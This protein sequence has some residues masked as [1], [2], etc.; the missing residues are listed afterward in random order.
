MVVNATFA[1]RGS[2]RKTDQKLGSRGNLNETVSSIQPSRSIERSKISK[3]SFGHKIIEK[4]VS[5]E[6][7][8][9]KPIAGT[10]IIGNT[11][12]LPDN[13]LSTERSLPRAIAGFR[14]ATG[15]DLISAPDDI[16]SPIGKYS[17][18][19]L[20]YPLMVSI[21]PRDLADR[22][23]EGGQVK[24]ENAA[25][26]LIKDASTFPVP[27]DR[28]VVATFFG[29]EEP[30]TEGY[31]KNAEGQP[32]TPVYIHNLGE[33]GPVLP[34][35]LGSPELEKK[36]ITKDDLVKTA[37]DTLHAKGALAVPVFMFGDGQMMRKKPDGTVENL[38]WDDMSNQDWS[39]SKDDPN[40]PSSLEVYARNIAG[41]VKKYGADGADFD[42]FGHFRLPLGGVRE[43]HHYSGMG[44]TPE[45]NQIKWLFNRVKEL[46][47]RQDLIFTGENMGG[48]LGW[49]G[50]PV[51]E[52][53]GLNAA[54]SAGVGGP[55]NAAKC[56]AEQNHP[57][58]TF[59]VGPMVKPGVQE[60]DNKEAG[61]NWD[62]IRAG[63]WKAL[64]HRVP[65]AASIYDIKPES[66]ENSRAASPKARNMGDPEAL[67]YDNPY[68]G[69]PGAAAH[70]ELQ[71]RAITG[72][73]G[74]AKV[75]TPKRPEKIKAANTK[76][77]PL[78]KIDN[79][80]VVAP[81]SLRNRNLLPA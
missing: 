64:Q 63:T 17:R 68:A 10:K 56:E 39:R 76:F 67:K 73:F 62:Q 25:L 1:I 26:N 32:L 3:L 60:F 75:I 20:A 43:G 40:K 15:V 59:K 70:T 55:D 46:S 53:I 66:Y 45:Y 31:M 57:G 6:R 18:Q 80:I 54:Y 79:G 12:V 28:P 65:V 7:G 13:R 14:E 16:P 9:L 58:R 33:D 37:I 36:G 77:T 44:K 35:E 22:K 27:K 61:D 2:A 47:G 81:N 8:P 49:D 5:L 48:E 34:D 11:E 38:D 50:R 74:P 78:A 4:L 24:L 42:S 72:D 29:L 51:G 23:I 69:V 30:R 21:S 52:D 19:E 71:V 41:F